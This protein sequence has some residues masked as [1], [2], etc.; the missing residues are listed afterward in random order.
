MGLPKQEGAG[1][2][3]E[4]GCGAREKSNHWNL[5]QTQEIRHAGTLQ[6]GRDPVNYCV[7]VPLQ[8]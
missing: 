3:Q 2:E 6:S 7:I 1:Q 5:P 8:R 4:A